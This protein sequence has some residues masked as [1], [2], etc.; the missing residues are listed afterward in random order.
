MAASSE[1]R[2]QH[3]S[4]HGSAVVLGNPAYLGRLARDALRYDNIVS[5][6]TVFRPLPGNATKTWCSTPTE[7]RGWTRYG[8]FRA[9]CPPKSMAVPGLNVEKAQNIHPRPENIFQRFQIFRSCLYPYRGRSRAAAP[10]EVRAGAVLH[11]RRSA[12]VPPG[13]L[14]RLARFVVTQLLRPLRRR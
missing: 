2:T 9:R 14:R 12:S 5:P 11:R 13:F 6:A 4:L 10:G 1:V 8:H 7:C 3:L